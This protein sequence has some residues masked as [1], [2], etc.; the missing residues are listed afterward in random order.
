[1]VGI[2]QLLGQDMVRERLGFV[3]S[4]IN[5]K[6]VHPIELCKILNVQ[7]VVDDN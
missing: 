1:M 5:G 4:V 7:Y 3:L 2:Q 6:P